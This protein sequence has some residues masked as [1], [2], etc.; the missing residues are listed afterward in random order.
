METGSKN[1]KQQYIRKVYTKDGI[2]QIGDTNYSG[3]TFMTVKTVETMINNG[4][5]EAVVSGPIP[6]NQ[7]NNF[8]YSMENSKRKIE[9]AELV[10]CSPLKC[11][12]HDDKLGKVLQSPTSSQ[13]STI[14]IDV[15]NF[16]LSPRPTSSTAETVVLDS[17]DSLYH[18]WFPVMS[19]SEHSQLIS[20]LDL[21]RTTPTTTTND[22]CK[23]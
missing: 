20:A 14:V 17:P 5:I 8:T 22:V 11:A 19:Q 12:K 23:V 13:A 15:E 18:D 9:R 10:F 3:D 7:A 6:K 21:Q 4:D 16:P 2:L 1:N